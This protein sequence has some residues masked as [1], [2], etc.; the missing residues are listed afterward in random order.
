[1]L[2]AQFIML[3]WAADLMERRGS[4]SVAEGKS[5]HTWWLRSPA[6]ALLILV[7]VGGTVYEV[8]ILRAYLPGR[9]LGLV[10]NA[11]T[12][13]PDRQFGARAFELRRAYEYLDRS[14]PPHAKVQSSPDPKLFDFYNGLYSNR[15]TVASDGACGAVFGGDPSPCPAA[16]AEVSAIFD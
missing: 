16:L 5:F 7:G 10:T 6:W 13:S 2:P 1:F 14:L 8:I 3:L 15:Q 11:L 12:Y 9:D 4:R